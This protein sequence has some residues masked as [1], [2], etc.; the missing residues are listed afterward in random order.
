M[1][2]FVARQV[3]VPAEA[4]R[5]YGFTGRTVEYHR[6]QIR[7]HFGYRECT[8]EDAGALQG[9]LAEQRR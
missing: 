7:E 6:A 8:V 2:E 4:L 5:G 9:W 1:V 3:H